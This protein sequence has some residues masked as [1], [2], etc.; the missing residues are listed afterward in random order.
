MAQPEGLHGT[1]S[2]YGQE[3]AGRTTANGEI[4]D[5]LLL[6]AAHRTLPFGTVVDVRN[7]KTGKTVRVRINDRGP[8][9]GNRII[10]LSFAAASE[11]DLVEPGSGEVDLTIVRVGR[12]EKEPPAPYVVSIPAP[13]QTVSAGE[14]PKVDF[15]LPAA[16]P[17]VTPPPATG[18]QDFHVEVIEEHKS[19]PATVRQVAADGKTITG[20]S[21]Q[22][23]RTASAPSPSSAIPA[24]SAVRPGAA[25][26]AGRF[27]V[28]LGAFQQE[29]NATA[30]QQKLVAIGQPAFVDHSGSL[31][32][33]RMGPFAARDQ[34]V[35][36]REALQ[37][38]GIS[39]I[40]VP[41]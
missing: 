5:P 4:F 25:A 24:A 31:F 22:A 35:K 32:R 3:F 1:A 16:A 7:A 23:P 30:L 11:I 29:A 38:A 10:D 36:T 20:V 40:V 26:P 39:A 14:P 37:D 15:P 33:V 19:S 17:Q 9:V 18:E 28:Q 41:E 12:G 34:A 6:T 8:F 13:T 27:V 2:W 21:P